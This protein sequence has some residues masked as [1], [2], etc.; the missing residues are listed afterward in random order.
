MKARRTGFVKV[1]QQRCRYICA[2]P[3]VVTV[4]ESLMLCCVLQQCLCPDNSTL[5]VDRGMECGAQ[6]MADI[7]AWMFLLDVKQSNVNVAY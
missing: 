1:S 7:S 5:G 3:F 2:L 6:L 4:P